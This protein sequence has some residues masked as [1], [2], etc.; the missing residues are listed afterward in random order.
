MKIRATV[1]ILLCAFLAMAGL[2]QAQTHYPAG[3]EGIKG[4]QLPPPGFYLRDYNYIYFAGEFENGP[5]EFD[6][7]AYIQVPRL[8]WITNHKI[9]GGFYGMDVIVPFAYQNLSFEGYSGSDFSLADI[10]VEPITISWHGEKFDAAVGYGFWAPSGDFSTSD[11]V[12]PGKGF[13]TQMITGGVTYYPD[14]AKTWSLSALNRYEINQEM[15]S[16]GATP[17]QYWTLDFGI[18][19][20]ITK[21]VEVGLAGYHQMATTDVSGGQMINSEK[22][23]VTALGPEITIAF[24]ASGFF[25]SARYLREVSTNDNRQQG[26][27]INITFTKRF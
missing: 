12:S 25:T 9:L 18:G 21:T 26:N 10:F 15:E 5:P 13:W 24:P 7:F 19:K 3:A 14:A 16:T 20:S 11:P 23:R 17:G 4:P 8:V 2:A 1:V 22:E 27:T 6:L